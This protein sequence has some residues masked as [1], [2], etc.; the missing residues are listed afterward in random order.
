MALRFHSK[1]LFYGLDDGTWSNPPAPWPNDGSSGVQPPSSGSSGS[2]GEV[3]DSLEARSLLGPRGAG[4]SAYTGVSMA[5]TTSG[6]M[7]FD[8]SF[9][10]LE[11]MAAG[12]IGSGAWEAVAASV[13]L[14]S[15]PSIGSWAHLSGSCS[16]CCFFPKGRCTNGYS[17]RFCH[18]DHDKPPRNGKKKRGGRG[19]FD[20]ESGDAEAFSGED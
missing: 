1:L 10:S 4:I 18:L 9:E 5:S 7:Q 13:P 2:C 14:A 19:G 17:C 16:R 20:A 6:S 8:R 3:V 11:G 12:I 15:V